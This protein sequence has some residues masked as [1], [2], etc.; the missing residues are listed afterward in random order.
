[1]QDR[2][3]P[4]EAKCLG[5]DSVSVFES[6]S[7]PGSEATWLLHVADVTQRPGALSCCPGLRFSYISSIASPALQLRSYAFIFSETRPRLSWG[8][9]SE[10][11]LAFS[12]YVGSSREFVSLIVRVNRTSFRSKRTRVPC[13]PILMVVEMVISRRMKLRDDRRIRHDDWK[14]TWFADKMARTMV[15]P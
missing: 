10:P 2:G 3:Q 9:V 7:H 12:V 11:K 8:N 14:I 4:R 6:G 13:R 5:T 15:P 1:M